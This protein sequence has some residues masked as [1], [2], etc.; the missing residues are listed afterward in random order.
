MDGQQVRAGAMV[1]SRC[2]PFPFFG[3]GEELDPF[4]FGKGCLCSRKRGMN[5]IKEQLLLPPT[6]IL[7][8]NKVAVFPSLPGE[9]FPPL[10]KRERVSNARLKEC[11][12]GEGWGGWKE[13]RGK[14]GRE[15]GR[16]VGRG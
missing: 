14:E 5:F 9:S 3:V 1:V 15:G 7:K 16:G 2:R 13:G 11:G 6:K 12:P 4:P 10:Q 8:S